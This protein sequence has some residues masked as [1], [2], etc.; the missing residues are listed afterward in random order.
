MTQQWKFVEATYTVKSVFIVPAEWDDEE[1]NVKWNK[2]EY[3]NFT[4]DPALDC[5]EAEHKYPDDLEIT[6]DGDNYTTEEFEE[7]L[8]ENYPT[9]RVSPLNDGSNKDLEKP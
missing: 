5:M 6:A 1:I 7:W 4:V 2:L 8:E 3:K 9:L